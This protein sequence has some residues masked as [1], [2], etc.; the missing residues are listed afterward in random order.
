MTIDI[1]AAAVDEG[2]V[3][4]AEGFRSCVH[5]CDEGGFTAAYEFSHGDT[6]GIYG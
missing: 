5:F 1:Q 2:G 6:C 3:F 4:H